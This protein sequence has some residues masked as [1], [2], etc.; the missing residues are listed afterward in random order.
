MMVEALEVVAL[1]LFEQRG[2]DAVTIED[3]AA[4]AQISAR[5]FYR[6]FPAKEDVLQVAI[7]RRSEALRSALE[8]RPEDEPPLHSLSQA[9]ETVLSGEDPAAVRRWIGV[10]QA[11]PGVLRS[12]VGGIQLK[13]HRV[14]AEFF[15]SRMGLSGDALVPTVLAAA[16]GG[17]IQAGQ[18]QW[19]LR[20]GDLATTVSESLGVLE[21]AMGATLPTG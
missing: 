5:T 21:S 3:I 4:E 1:R 19:Y 2:F 11:T 12:V 6:Y 8:A 16:T 10:I 17:V 7:E 9:L 18:T 15:G 13:S 20:G 14:I